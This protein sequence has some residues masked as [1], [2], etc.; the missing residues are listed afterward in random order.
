MAVALNF[1]VN[2]WSLYM[3]RLIVQQKLNQFLCLPS[4]SDHLCSCVFGKCHVYKLD[5]ILFVW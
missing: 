2:H 1:F 5:I 3:D 4:L